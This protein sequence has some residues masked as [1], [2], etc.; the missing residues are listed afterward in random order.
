MAGNR[1]RTLSSSL[2]SEQGSRFLGKYNRN[3]IVDAGRSWSEPPSP[4]LSWFAVE[5]LQPLLLY[6]F[7]VN[8]DARSVLAT[9]PWSTLAS[10]GQPFRRWRRQGGFGE[11]LLESFAPGIEEPLQVQRDVEKTCRWLSEIRQRF[12][13]GTMT[14]PLHS[15]QGW[16]IEDR[17]I[18]DANKGAYGVRHYRI[19]TSEREVESWDQ[20]LVVAPGEGTATLLC[21]YRCGILRFLFSGRA[22]PGLRECVQL[23]PTVQFIEGPGEIFSELES[24]DRTLAAIATNGV[25]ILSSLHSDEGGRCFNCISRYSVVEI[26]EDDSLP[27]FDTSVWLTLA[28]ISLLVR[29]QGVFTNEARTLVSLLLAF[30]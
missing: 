24:R 26:P 29:F 27:D 6:D 17:S 25:Q 18:H 7:A 12:P 30:A 3:V 13:F 1:S 10:D 14:V 15:L 21:Q 5:E 19:E 4:A 8:T 28:E 22:E 23:G 20:P 11:A 9:A 16:R 2:Q